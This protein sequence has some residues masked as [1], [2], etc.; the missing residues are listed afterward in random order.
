MKI[1]LSVALAFFL[2]GCSEDTES[3][4]AVEKAP[5]TVSQQV[6]EV[7]TVVSK[8]TQ[9]VVKKAQEATAEVVQ[10][11]AE[12]TKESVKQVEAVSAEVVQQAKESGTKAAAAV[13]QST[14]DMAQK[15][16]DAIV[17]PVKKAPAK[18]VAAKPSLDGATLF[19][20]CA[21]CHGAHAQNKAMGRSQVIKGWPAS[22]VSDALHG[23]QKGT[24][25]GAMK[26][27]M[28]GQASKLSDAE[29]SAVAEF[30]SKQ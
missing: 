26:A 22:K 12:V 29:I 4:K 1:V 6:S 23:Y 28:K 3:H 7:S 16:H 10:K 13:A 20:T 24:Y 27:I 11:A 25:G 19:K 8:Q 5:Q 17:A 15:A 18:V 9:E 30:V 14:A 2:F 21:G